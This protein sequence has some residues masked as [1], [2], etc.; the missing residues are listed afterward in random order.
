MNGNSQARIAI[1]YSLDLAKRANKQRSTAL[2]IDDLFN[3]ERH[4]LSEAL[5]HSKLHAAS[6]V[7]CIRQALHPF[8]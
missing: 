8:R 3:R 2:A 6:Q 5:T 7:T 4:D 1:N